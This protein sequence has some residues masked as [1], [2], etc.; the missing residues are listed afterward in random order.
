MRSSFSVSSSVSLKTGMPVQID[1]TSAISSSSTSDRM[2]ISPDFHSAL[3]AGALLLQLALL[4]AERRGAL[5]VLGVDGRFLAQA[6]LGDLLVDLADVGRRGHATDA[7]AGA[8]L[9]D[10]VDGLVGQEPVADVAV[11]EVRGRDQR[12]VGEVHAVVRLVP[13][14]QALQ[15]LDG[16]RRRWARRP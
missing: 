5:E 8:G 1:R 14:A 9:V 3:A 6:H 4:V 2:S 12:V 7:H 15:D 10:E 11:G 16:V 13:V